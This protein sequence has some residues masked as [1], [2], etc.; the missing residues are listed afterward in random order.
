[1]TSR[2]RFPRTCPICGRPPGRRTIGLP[3]E[4]PEQPEQRDSALDAYV[5][6]T[7]THPDERAELDSRVR[8]E[9]TFGFRQQQD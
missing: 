6:T 1:M 5:E 7:G 2:L 9:L 3:P 8:P 4:P